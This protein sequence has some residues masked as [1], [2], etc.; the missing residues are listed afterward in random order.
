MAKRVTIETDGITSV[1]GVFF[2]LAKP[3]ISRQD[4]DELLRML[5]RT[6]VNASF[7][8]KIESIEPQLKSA[9]TGHSERFGSRAYYANEM[10]KAIGSIRELQNL[11]HIDAALSMAMRLGWLACEA[12]AKRWPV[13]GLGVR[14]R[15]VQS[16][17][18]KRSGE[19]RQDPELEKAVRLYFEKH[20]DHS[21]PSAAR[22]LCST[23]GTSSTKQ[24]E[25]SLAKRI[26]RIRKKS[27]Q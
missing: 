26:Y 8:R 12:E 21:V 25:K 18:G 13:V 11:G 2:D 3:S 22:Y 20:P 10:L 14:T 5:E 6:K 23:F 1:A 7:K 15:N 4:A 9:A 24:S 16:E 19:K 27:S 17:R